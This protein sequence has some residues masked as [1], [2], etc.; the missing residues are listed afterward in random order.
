MMHPFF[1][2]RHWPMKHLVFC[3]FVGAVVQRWFHVLHFFHK[4]RVGGSE[5][6]RRCGCCIFVCL[7]GIGFVV[8]L[9]IVFVCL[10]S[11]AVRPNTPGLTAT[12]P[13]SDGNLSFG[14]IFIDGRP[15]RRVA[16]PAPSGSLASEDWEVTDQ[17]KGLGQRYPRVSHF[18]M[19]TQTM[20]SPQ[21]TDSACFRDD[22][23]G[24]LSPPTL[25]ALT[26]RWGSPLKQLMKKSCSRQLAVLTGVPESATLGRTSH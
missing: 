3:L 6:S 16:A 24:H 1:V 14:C 21:V 18:G 5:R 26:W 13:P 20:E 19:R 8:E 2:S 11:G 12:I 4:Q 9:H 22:D 23:L 10:G 17:F 25:A 15:F 7:L